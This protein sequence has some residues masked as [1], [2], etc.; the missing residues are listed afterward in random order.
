[1]VVGT[2]LQYSL[3]SQVDL[4]ICG[5]GKGLATPSVLFGGC[6]VLVKVDAIGNVLV[7]F[8][9]ICGVGA[10]TKAAT[11]YF[12]G[13]EG[14]R[15]GVVSISYAIFFRRKGTLQYQCLVRRGSLL[16]RTLVRDGNATWVSNSYMAS[17]RGVRNYLGLS[18]LSIKAIGSRG[19]GIYY[20]ARFRC[21][22]SRGTS[23]YTFSLFSVVVRTSRVLYH[24]VCL[25]V[26]VSGKLVPIRQLRSTRGV[27]GGNVVTFFAGYLTSANSY[28]SKSLSFYANSTYRCGSVRAFV[29]LSS[30]IFSFFMFFWCFFWS[31]VRGLQLMLLRWC[32]CG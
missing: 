22:Q 13:G 11:T 18:V 23:S 5:Y 6:L 20:L 31:L 21:V 9:I 3:S 26:F 17:P 28:C 30:L 2:L 12:C 19:C 4:S 32:C 14:F 24:E 1:M 16:N 7:F 29:S 27:C 8:L 10:C 15:A 25:V